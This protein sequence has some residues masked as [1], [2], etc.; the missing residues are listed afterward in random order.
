MNQEQREAYHLACLRQQLSGELA[1]AFVVENSEMSV[2]VSCHDL[3]DEFKI[4]AT[5]DKDGCN[6]L[7]RYEKLQ[8]LRPTGTPEEYYKCY[9]DGPKTIVMFM[10]KDELVPEK[11]KEERRRLAQ[12]LVDACYKQWP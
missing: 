12:L 7:I 2:S 4:G 6:V 1:V 11:G 8:H 9:K 5:R 3:A 10:W